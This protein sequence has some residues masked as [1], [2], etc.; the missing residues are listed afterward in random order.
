MA[1]ERRTRSW[2][3]RDGGGGGEALGELVVVWLLCSFEQWAGALDDAREDTLHFG[4]ARRRCG[5]EASLA[6]RIFAV[7]TIQ[8]KTV[9]V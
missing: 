3:R 7:G 8:E 9:E 5:E 4:R 1:E 2:W 6:A